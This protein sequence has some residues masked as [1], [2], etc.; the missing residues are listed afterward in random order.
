MI[1][2]PPPTKSE[3]ERFC[4]M[5]SAGILQT[6]AATRMGWSTTRIG[7]IIKYG[8]QGVPGFKEFLAA[9]D[10]EMDLGAALLREKVADKIA[11]GN[12]TAV[13]WDYER[14]YGLREKIREK[15]AA[16]AEIASEVEQAFEVPSDDDVA[17]AEA[18]ALG[19]ATAQA[20]VSEK[21]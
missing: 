5:I 11:E 3:T 1:K 9:F 4:R 10:Q 21:H 7:T 6:T 14:R 18:R 17:A 20:E 2:I 12:L 13:L 19:L 15:H 8:R 16:E